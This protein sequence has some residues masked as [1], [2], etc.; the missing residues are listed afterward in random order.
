MSGSIDVEA[1]RAITPGCSQ[2][3]HLNSAGAAL[4]ADPTVEAMI[5]HLRLEAG[6]GGYE[7]A[8]SVAER[9]RE[10]RTSAARLL[11]ADDGDVVVTGSDTQA[12]TKALWGF[13]LGGGVRRGQVLLTDRITYDSHYLGLL[14]VCALTGASVEVV[15]STEAGTVDLEAL[16]HGLDGERMAMVTLT[17]IGTHR[18]LVN[19]VEDA[20]AACRAAGVPFFLDACQSAGQL[21]VDVDRIGCDVATVTGRK[22]LRGPRGTGLLFVRG[23]FAERFEPPGIG[24]SAAEWEDADHYRL[25]PGSERFAEFEVSVAAHLGLGVAIDH[26][27]RLGLDA[28]AEQVGLLADRLRGAL[29]EVRGVELHDGGTRRSGIV[30]FTVADASPAAVAASATACGINIWVSEAPLARLDMSAPR[31]T[32]VVRASPHYYNTEEE[33]DRLVG[34]VAALGAG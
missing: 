33:L 20:G 1:E 15:P 24:W 22:W 19:P 11:G 14:Q 23:A 29:S 7:A 13:T 9:L 6:R 31:P 16:R 34:V 10:V 27:L 28:I 25:R 12:W 2:V 26:A 32:S 8:A 5:A 30:S 4:L 3:V 17:H 18:G 21:P